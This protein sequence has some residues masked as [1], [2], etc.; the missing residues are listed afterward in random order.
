MRDRDAAW[1]GRMLELNVATLLGD[2][3]PTIGLKRV[4]DIRRFH[5]CICTHVHGDAHKYTLYR[6]VPFVRRGIQG[7]IRVCG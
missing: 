2:L 6:K 3:F 7:T 1:R 5:V 4:D